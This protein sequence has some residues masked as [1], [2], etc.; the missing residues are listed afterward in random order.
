MSVDRPQP[1]CCVCRQTFADVRQLW[2]HVQTAHFGRRA[3]YGNRAALV[4]GIRFASQ[5]EARRYQQLRLLEQQGQIA[6]LEL[7]R[8]FCLVVNGRH[9]CDYVCDFCYT[10]LT[11]PGGLVVEDAKGVKTPVYRLKKK[12]LLACYGIEIQEV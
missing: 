11:P 5:R 3:K 6:V 10:R 4:D 9:V 1:W 2:E 12:L 7:Q 8:K